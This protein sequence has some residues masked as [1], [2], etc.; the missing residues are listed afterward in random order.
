VCYS[1]EGTKKYE[2]PQAAQYELPCADPVTSVSNI[3]KQK[4]KFSLSNSTLRIYSPDHSSKIELVEIYNIL[5][6]RVMEEKINSLQEYTTD[7]GF[8]EN[9]LYLVKI[10]G[11]HQTSVF[12]FVKN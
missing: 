1:E 2:S 9:G 12:K 3:L 11:D 10:S 6:N 8:L 5:G 7:I 4:L